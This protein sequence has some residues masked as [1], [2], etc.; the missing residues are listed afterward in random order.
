MSIA[1]LPSPSAIVLVGPPLSASAARSGL[2][3]DPGQ[4]VSPKD[5]LPPSLWNAPLA[6]VPQL[7]GEF[8]AT[9][10]F[11]I[12]ATLKAPMP[13]PP[14]RPPPPLGPVPPAPVAFPETVR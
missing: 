8:D 12:V 4:V 5:T 3:F 14:P 13:A 2:P 1:E 7:A 6:C 10:M 9:M 11:R